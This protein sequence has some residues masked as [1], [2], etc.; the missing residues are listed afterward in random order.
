MKHIGTG[1]LLLA[2]A[3]AGVAN[4][5]ADPQQG[6]LLITTDPVGAVVTCDGVVK[7][8]AP[9]TVSGVAAGN[10]LVIASKPGYTDAR[11][12]VTVALREK[13]PVNLRLSQLMGLLLVHSEP[14]GADIQV[15]GADRGKTPAL[16]YD[17]PI[18]D[19][20]MKLSLS[21]YQ[22][23]EVDLQVTDRTPRKLTI[24]LSSSSASLAIESDPTGAKLTLNGVDKGQTPCT[25]DR[26]PEG[27]TAIEIAMAGYAPFQKT[28]RLVSGQKE[29]LK[30]VLK[31]LTSQITVVS[32][33]P[34][35]RVYCDNLYQ[36]ETPV[37]LTNLNPGTYKIRTELR[38]YEI[39]SRPVTIKAGEKIP[40]E[41][42]LQKNSGIVEITTEPAGV[43]VFLDG[44]DVGVTKAKPDQ[45]DKVSEPL[46]IDTVS[47]G[48][49]QF[50]LTKKGFVSKTMSVNVEKDKTA[51][52]HQS[53][54][55]RFIPNY[56]IRTPSDTFTGVLV[57][58][59][60]KGNVKME[61]RPG[62]FKTFQKG[63]IRAQQPLR[64]VQEDVPE[65]PPA[66]SAPAPKSD[67]G[68]TT[69]KAA[70]VQD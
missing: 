10:H 65:K 61:V 62:I 50:Q 3:A 31:P 55:R 40:E 49:R 28:I 64:D 17:L 9:I 29:A 56:K 15:N 33:P 24:N 67:D 18:G 37:A 35:A 4:G 69:G 22:S 30:A 54:E 13:V 6:E 59:D 38:G 70:G 42:R 43:R 23:K 27:D 34:K 11:K 19:Y 21:G 46:T 26:V 48:E 60:P 8:T 7:G 58:I 45:T 39:M 52:V 20:R 12:T 68:A 41:F 5:Q 14:Q 44:E 47:T 57:D 16:I 1:I 25:I 36:G 53:L 66:R 32:I 51:T 2:L 63:D